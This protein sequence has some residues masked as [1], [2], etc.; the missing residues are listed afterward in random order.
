MMRFLRKRDRYA[1]SKPIK[2]YYYQ[3]LYSFQCL[4]LSLST[5]Y[6]QFS[7]NVQESRARGTTGEGGRGKKPAVMKPSWSMASVMCFNTLL[8]HCYYFEHT[9][10]I[11]RPYTKSASARVAGVFGLAS[12]LGRTLVHI[13]ST[14]VRLLFECCSSAVRVR[15]EAQSKAS[16]RAPEGLSNKC[17]SRLE[18]Q[19]KDCRRALEGLSNNSRSRVE[20]LANRLPRFACKNGKVMNDLYMNLLI[21]RWFESICEGVRGKV[22]SMLIKNK[23]SSQ[24]GLN[25]AGGFLF[26]KESVQRAQSLECASKFPVSRLNLKTGTKLSQYKFSIFG[27]SGTKRSDDIKRPMV[28]VLQLIAIFCVLFSFASA[29]EAQAQEPRPGGATGTSG[30]KGIRDCSLSIK[31]FS[32]ILFFTVFML[33]T[34]GIVSGQFYK[35]TEATL[36]KGDFLTDKLSKIKHQ[37]IDMKTGELGEIMLEDYQDKLVILDFWASWCGPCRASLKKMDRLLRDLDKSDVLILG[38]NYESPDQINRIRDQLALGFKSIYA[39]TILSKV[40]PHVG[41]PHM[42]WINRG[43]V[44]AMPKHQYVDLATVQSALTTGE[45]QMPEVLNDKI[46]NP[47]EEMFAGENG[48]AQLIY[49]NGELQVYAEN[50]FYIYEGIKRK[51]T[52]D[53]IIFYGNNLRPIE[54]LHYAYKNELFFPYKRY[55]SGFYMLDKYVNV[56][57]FDALDRLGLKLSFERGKYKEGMESDKLRELFAGYMQGHLGLQCELIPTAEVSY[58]VLKNKKPILYVENKLQSTKDKVKTYLDIDSVRHY[59]CLPFGSHFINAV[60]LRLKKIQDLAI[61]VAEVE[62]QSGVRPDLAVD[63]KLPLNFGSLQELNVALEEYGLVVEI[64]KERA[65]KLLITGKEGGKDV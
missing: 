37:S 29:M 30:K 13:C 34:G 14:G 59:E 44:I 19:S 12:K 46:L 61:S 38:V 9:W 33:L 28:Y 60:G 39:D 5:I 55:P 54:V 64:A 10:L 35:P 23:R 1:L 21:L 56:T 48:R 36:R 22:E 49:Q 31:V 51:E 27:T 17:R 6:Y 42:V 24:N 58:A 47:D 63:F 32:R 3:S 26:D 41:I 11:L 43:E 57:E 25:E 16:R 4:L 65:K 2:K 53:S 8:I 50:T 45:I 18:A 20:E 52:T 7:C 15:V 40:F 62:D